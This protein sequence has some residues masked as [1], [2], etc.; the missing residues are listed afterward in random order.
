MAL[1]P[2]KLRLDGEELHLVAARDL[3]RWGGFLNARRAAYT[4][5]TPHNVADIRHALMVPRWIDT[6]GVFT[7]LRKQLEDDS[8]L[9]FEVPPEP[10]TWDEPDIID[11]HDLIPD[12]GDDSLEPER[13]SPQ[14]GLHWIEVVCVSAQGGGFAGAKARVRLPDGRDEYVTLD[15]RSSVRFDDLTE[16]GTVHFE[17]SGDAVARGSDPVPLGQ[18]YELG[19]PV[20]LPTRKRHVLIVHPN[21]RA[22]V[23]VELFVEDTPVTVGRYTLTT[24]NGETAGALEGVVVR[25]EGF[26]LPSQSTYAFE[27]VIFPPRPPEEEDDVDD[28]DRT[29][30]DDVIDDD[31]HPDD[32]PAKV[33][34]PGP[35]VDPP[36]PLGP[37]VEPDHLVLILED[38]G[39][40]PVAHAEVRLEAAGAEHRST[41]DASGRVVFADL[42][43]GSGEVD[44]QLVVSADALPEPNPPE[45]P[46]GEAPED[47]PQ[48]EDDDDFEPGEPEG[49]PA[50]PYDEDE[51]E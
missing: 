36:G 11:I 40:S 43:A 51:D 42:P 20:G 15:G 45:A 47:F 19:A 48:A 14:P 13:P 27:G 31:D 30:D 50:E 39:G 5:V 49:E 41:T 38:E 25:E 44:A 17:L 3:Q 24:K 9:F 23:S 33:D 8:A 18:R 35:H 22:F 34:P 12:G 21:P 10:V 29:D 32:D 2:I 28:D 6:E 37:D 4:L 1:R 7:E 46:L 16:G 26:M